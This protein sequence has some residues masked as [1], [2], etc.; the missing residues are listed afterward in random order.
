MWKL[1][2]FESWCA[3]MYIQR[4]ASAR[5]FG[6]LPC[7]QHAKDTDSLQAFYMKPAGLNRDGEGH[8]NDCNS[9]QDAH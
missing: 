2:A 6:G 7:M 1:A 3:W 8:R 4:Q 9:M 5:D